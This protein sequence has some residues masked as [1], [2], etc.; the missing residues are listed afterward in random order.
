MTHQP[1]NPGTPESV[2]ADIY[3]LPTHDAR[4]PLELV[5]TDFLEKLR[6]G[7]QPNVEEYASRHPAQADQIGRFLPLVAA[8]EAWK[9][10]RDLELVCKTIPHT[11]QIERLGDCRIIRE[12]GRGGMGVVYEAVQEPIGR[13]VAVKM[14]PWRFPR[15]STAWKRFQREA[16]TAARIRHAHIVPVFR[17]GEYQG[18]CYYVM[19]LVEGVGLDRVIGL[20]RETEDAVS[21]NQIRQLFA[22][23]K[24]RPTDQ[25]VE[26]GFYDFSSL[27]TADRHRTENDAH[28]SQSNSKCLLRRNSWTQIATIG[29]HVAQALHYAHSQG[30]LH[31][32]IKPANLLLDTAGTVWVT[33]FG[34]AL[35]SNP[36][37]R[38]D[39]D[40]LAGTLR[41]IAPEQWEGRVDERSDV[42]SLGTTLYELCTLQP[43]YEATGQDAL[44]EQI[45][46]EP[47]PSP[48][49]ANPDV[50]EELD[51]ILVKAMAKDPAERF[52]SAGELLVALLQFEKSDNKPA[53]TNGLFGRLKR[54]FTRGST[55]GG[56]P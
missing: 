9:T 40:D 7:T 46:Q 3:G 52:Q 2:E 4:A 24:Q 15:S 14:L 56:T 29:I 8:M 17:F 42:Y 31:R 22:P 43:A 18:W 11:L 48:R 50:P 33:D 49:V 47:Q 45:R 41:Y 1:H 39:R 12:I 20:L 19:R 54:M 13:P 5:A 6:D 36:I 28:L 16:R 23:T 37:L 25:P 30:T 21:A 34:L 53:E 10:N 51:R 55:L 32:D 35:K 27:P 44:I 38:T 26:S